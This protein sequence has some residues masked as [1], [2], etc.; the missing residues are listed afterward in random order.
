MAIFPPPP[1]L[2][3]RTCDEPSKDEDGLTLLLLLVMAIGIEIDPRLFVDL[4]VVVPLRI[5]KMESALVSAAAVT[6][7]TEPLASS[8]KLVALSDSIRLDAS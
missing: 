7:A 8:E 5:E 1:P 4:T 6:A 2:L 3:A